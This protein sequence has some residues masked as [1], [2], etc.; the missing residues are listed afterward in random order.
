MPSDDSGGF[1][2]DEGATVTV[3]VREDLTNGPIVAKFTAEV[4]EIRDRSGPMGPVAR[5][6]LPFGTL[7]T[8]TIQPHEGEFEVEEPADADTDDEDG[9][10]YE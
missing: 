8:V 2:F 10:G 6:D 5:F 4:E 9:D 1:P 7:N 3:R